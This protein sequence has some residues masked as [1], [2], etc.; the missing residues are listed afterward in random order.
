MK[1]ASKYIQIYIKR[2]PWGQRKRGLRRQV[3][4]QQDKKKVTFKYRLLLNR[5]NRFGRFDCN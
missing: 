1:T 3:V 4:L 2:S 5:G